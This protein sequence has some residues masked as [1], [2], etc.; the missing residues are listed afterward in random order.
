MHHRLN[1]LAHWQASRPPRQRAASPAGE[2]GKRRS[3]R[4]SYV[5]L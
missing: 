4:M 1:A 5:N 3:D 2:H